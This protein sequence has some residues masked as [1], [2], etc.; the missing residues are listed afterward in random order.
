MVRTFENTGNVP[1]AIFRRI[2]Q[3]RLRQR[4]TELV[5]SEFRDS[6]TLAETISAKAWELRLLH[7]LSD[8]GH[9]GQAPIMLFDLYS[10]SVEG[11][12]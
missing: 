7:I 11:F 10:G 6:I 9:H 3:A 12:E 2:R 4:Q 1:R 5:E 8:T